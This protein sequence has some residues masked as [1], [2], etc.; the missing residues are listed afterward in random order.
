VQQPQKT[1]FSQPM[2]FNNDTN[3]YEIN[4]KNSSTTKFAVAINPKT[5]WAVIL[6]VIDAND[7]L[8]RSGPCKLDLNKPCHISL[9]FKNNKID[10]YNLD[11]K[12]YYPVRNKI[13]SFIITYKNRG[14]MVVK[15]YSKIVTFHQPE[16]EV[17]P[18][19]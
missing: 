4:V 13:A 16:F 19:Q 10:R 12:R 14:D 15:A 5:E 11:L 8:G 17:I 18:P 6:G 3:F 7:K 2:Q 9:L 1:N